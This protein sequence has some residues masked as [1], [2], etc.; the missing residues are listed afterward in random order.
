MTREVQRFFENDFST[1]ERNDD[2][3]RSFRFGWRHAFSPGSTLIGYFTI[4]DAEFRFEDILDF[5][6]PFFPTRDIL[7][8]KTD[9][10]AAG[11]EIQHLF[12]SQYVNIT[13]GAGYFHI[14]RTEFTRDDVFDLFFT[15]PLFLDSFS[16][17]I[18]IDI[19]HAN[20]YLYTYIYFPKNVI[21][22]LGASG[23]F[24]H[25][26]VQHSDNLDTNKDRL[27]PKFGIT[28]NP[29]AGTT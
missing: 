11:S 22:T 17:E 2:E 13:S 29:F 19:D 25:S 20:L 6:D 8:I 23:D 16:D 4:Q 5:D 14:D 24:F 28:W 15:P 27:N 10:D 26:D 21:F 12:D 18:K 1:N 9:D 3:T 7:T